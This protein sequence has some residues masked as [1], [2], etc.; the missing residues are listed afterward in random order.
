MRFYQALTKIT[1]LCL[2]HFCLV[3]YMES[4]SGSDSS[5]PDLSA[6]HVTDSNVNSFFSPHPD[7]NKYINHCDRAKVVSC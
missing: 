4:T 6:S 2:L 3:T 7:Q 5:A 1:F